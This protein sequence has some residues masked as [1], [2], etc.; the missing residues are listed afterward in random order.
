[1]KSSK[2]VNDKKYLYEK[3]HYVFKMVVYILPAYLYH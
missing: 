2:I 3:N 1:M